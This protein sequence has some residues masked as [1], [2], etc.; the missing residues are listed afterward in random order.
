VSD[1][2]LVETSWQMSRQ[3]GTLS[4]NGYRSWMLEHS[5]RLYKIM[6]D[7]LDRASVQNA[8]AE[9]AVNERRRLGGGK[10]AHI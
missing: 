9:G 2:E 3:G 4:V 10:F 8:Q 5:P 1:I 7:G 6:L